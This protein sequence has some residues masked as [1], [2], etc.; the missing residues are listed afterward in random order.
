MGSI[1]IAESKLFV[2]LPQMSCSGFLLFSSL[3][4]MSI[5]N[6][7]QAVGTQA[8]LPWLDKA[9]SSRFSFPQ[10]VENRTWQQLASF[11][12]SDAMLISGGLGQLATG[13]FHVWACFGAPHP[14]L[15]V[16]S[17]APGD[18]MCYAFN[19]KEQLWYPWCLN[20][21]RL[22]CQRYTNT[23]EVHHEA[24]SVHV[25][26]WYKFDHNNTDM[27]LDHSGNG[28]HLINA[29]AAFDGTNFRWGDG[30]MSFSSSSLQ[31]ADFPPSL[32]LSAVWDSGNGT[33]FSLWVRMS[34]HTQPWSRLF[35]FGDP[36]AEYAGQNFYDSE[37]RP[38]NW[39]L[40]YR[41]EEDSFL[42]AAIY[43][44]YASEQ[45]T[46]PMTDRYCLDD[47]WHHVVWSISREGLWSLYWDG[48]HVN[49]G[50]TQT[51]FTIPSGVNWSKQHLG[52]QVVHFW[53]Y[54]NGYLT[55]GV[56]DFRVY[57]RV[58]NATEAGILFSSGAEMS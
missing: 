58:L 41:H 8:S 43:R 31:Y 20:S 19:D 29:G 27:L 5:I 23:H 9:K 22:L 16:V 17:H 53:E 21:E 7:T 35:D 6:S 26:A 47:Q 13:D 51:R 10:C 28:H 4:L 36:A 32:N 44:N 39:V 45:I 14:C 3:L 15:S 40:L 34:P 11:F 33:T 38:R 18:S 24:I 49:P 56:D 50:D 46:Y 37:F 54:G 57:N 55:G 52:R 48:I 1:E 30:S 42:T 12:T 2:S 25:A